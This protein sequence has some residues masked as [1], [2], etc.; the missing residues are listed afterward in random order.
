[1][2]VTDF[3]DDFGLVWLIMRLGSGFVDHLAVLVLV[4]LGHLAL[5]V[6]VL[7]GLFGSRVLEDLASLLVLV[8]DGLGGRVVNT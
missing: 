1:M 7:A 4:F 8:K 5:A 2:T 6:L 3:E